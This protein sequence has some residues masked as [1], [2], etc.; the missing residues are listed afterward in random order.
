MGKD[1]NLEYE[2]LEPQKRQSRINLESYWGVFGCVC[3]VGVG[4][5]GVGS[6][7]IRGQIIC[8]IHER[9]LTLMS[10]LRL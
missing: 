3:G 2:N 6:D 4:G 10:H 8:E 9:A 7:R 1:R 5:G